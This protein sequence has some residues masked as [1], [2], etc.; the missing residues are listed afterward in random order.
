V[1]NLGNIVQEVVGAGGDALQQIVGNYKVSFQ[2]WIFPARTRANGLVVEHDRSGG[3]REAGWPRPYPED[4]QVR[5]SR[6]AYRHCLQH[7]RPSRP[8]RGAETDLGRR[9]QWVFQL[10]IRNSNASN[11]ARQLSYT[12]ERIVKMTRQIA[13]I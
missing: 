6:F 7:R 10:G 3:K 11:I 12:G 8:G 2:V 5:R 9:R 4:F 1:D 13:L